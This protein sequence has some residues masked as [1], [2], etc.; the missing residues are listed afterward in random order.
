M[1]SVDVVHGDECMAP[2]SEKVRHHRDLE[3]C[4][5]K[6]NGGELEGA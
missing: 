5:I 4:E 1:S 6:P 3:V 2:Y